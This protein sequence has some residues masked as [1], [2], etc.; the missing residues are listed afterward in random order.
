MK[1]LSY[2]VWVF[3]L[4]IVSQ[5]SVAQRVVTTAAVIENSQ[6]ITSELVAEVIDSDTRVLSSYYSAH[7]VAIKKVGEQVKEGDVIAELDTQFLQ[8]SEQKKQFEIRQIEIQVYYLSVELNRIETL[9]K[10]KSVNQSELDQLTYELKSAQT[11][12]S[13]LKASLTEIQRYIALSTIR[14]TENG[15]VAETFVR[16][17]EYLQ[18]GDAIARVNS[19]NDIELVSQLP[20][21]L[22]DYI[23]EQAEFI[24]ESELQVPR[25]IG[26]AKF[27]RLVPEVSVGTGSITLLVEPE[28]AL[29]SELVLGSNLLIKLSIAIP[30]SFVIPGDALIPRGEN[31]FVYKLKVD[32]SVEKAYVKVLAGVNGDYVVTGT[33]S[34][35]EEVITR[36]GLGLKS[37]EVVKVEQRVAQL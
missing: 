31:S 26:T 27:A 6:G 20:I 29:K 4:L 34:A 9:S 13:E 32:N 36:G 22:L 19:F 24:I 28:Q 12:L 7:V 1:V 5:H 14:A 2:Q 15:F 30:N 37:G 21:E 25:R 23:D 3:L 10:T 8:L 16:K 11:K 33:L 18:Q 17:G 35:G